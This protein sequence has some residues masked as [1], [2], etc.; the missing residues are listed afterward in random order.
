MLEKL[1]KLVGQVLAKRRAGVDALAIAD[2][3]RQRGDGGMQLTSPDF[4]D[5]AALPV[6]CSADGAGRSPALRISGVPQGTQSLV[7]LV[8][9]ADAPSAKPIVHA[10]AWGLPADLTELPAG[11]LD[12]AGSGAASGKTGRNSFMRSGWLP[13]DPPTGHGLHHYVFQLY[14]LGAPVTFDKSPGRTALLAAMDGRI[15][16]ST[17]LTGTYERS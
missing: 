5:R 4:A 15:L 14:A 7:L 10:I 12:G 13:P 2:L 3:A 11:A 16:A 8:E 6:S 17:V 1:P 9:D